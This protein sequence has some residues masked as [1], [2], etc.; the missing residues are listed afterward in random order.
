MI[1][2]WDK[3]SDHIPVSWPHWNMLWWQQDEK[4]PS[5]PYSTLRISGRKMSTEITHN[6]L[7]TH[8]FDFGGG[9]IPYGFEFGNCRTVFLKVVDRKEVT[10][11]PGASMR[12][13]RG[14]L[15]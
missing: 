7:S 5:V 6:P 8:L 14:K 12:I 9:L 11:G 3:V 13:Q 15:N 4:Q 1:V 10:S 2:H